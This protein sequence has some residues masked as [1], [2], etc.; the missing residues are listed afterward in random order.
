MIREP[1]EPTGQPQPPLNPHKMLQR[2]ERLLNE[3]R[4][5]KRK[6]ADEAQ[7]LV[8]DAW[9]APT[10]ERQHE[11]MCQALELDP[12]NADALLYLLDQSGLDE[13]AEIQALRNIVA[14]AAKSLGPKVFKEN[15]GHFWGF[16]ETRP[17]MRARQRLAYC[18]RAAGRLEEAITEYEAMLE[19][20]PNDNQGVRYELLPALLGLNRLE[21]AR[22]LL[23]QYN[24]A[25]FSVA[26]AWCAVLERWLSGDLAAAKR[27]L[28]AARKQNA[29]MQV[30]IKGHRDLPRQMPDSYAMGSKEEALCF[31][32]VLRSAWARHPQALAWLAEQQIK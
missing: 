16:I 12:G 15:A 1:D 5:P 30:Y 25:R 23:K 27:A 19:L 24:E 13:E 20:N 7:Q 11:L 3:T 17:Y 29:H 4:S 14:A 28:A 9:E 2:M 32:E 21:P 8:Y 18:L 31:A 26:F 6:Q 10:D 22:A